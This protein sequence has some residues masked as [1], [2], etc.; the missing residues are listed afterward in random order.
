MLKVKKIAA[1]YFLA[2]LLPAEILQ[3]PANLLKLFLIRKNQRML[4]IFT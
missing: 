2:N 4:F 1:L 3:K